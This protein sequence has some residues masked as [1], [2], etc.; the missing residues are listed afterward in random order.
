M[1]WVPSAKRAQ[2]PQSFCFSICRRF[3]RN[4]QDE[5]AEITASAAECLSFVSPHNAASCVLALLLYATG[6]SLF[7][8]EALIKR[9]PI[10]GRPRHH[11]V[12]MRQTVRP[13]DV[14][15]SAMKT[16]ITNDSLNCCLSAPTARQNHSR[17]T[18]YN[19]FRIVSLQV[20]TRAIGSVNSVSSSISTSTKEL[21]RVIFHAE[22][23]QA[24]TGACF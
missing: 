23:L 2:Q 11:Q 21:A 7:D 4:Q 15:L 1:Q 10:D 20:Y 18:R 17:R 3:A 12:V 16:A 5:T 6:A 9:L 22:T 14:A 24:Q 13:P 19:A 8:D